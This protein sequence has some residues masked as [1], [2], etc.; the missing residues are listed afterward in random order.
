MRIHPLKLAAALLLSA[1]G[2]AGAQ[3]LLLKG[4]N[5]VDVDLGEIVAARTVLVSDGRI[6]AIAPDA[7]PPA[8]PGAMVIDARGRYLMPALWD[9]HVHPDHE[10]D[11]A[12]FVANGVGGVR[13]MAGTPQHLAWRAAI[14]L[15]EKAG[16]RLLV[17]GPIVEGLPPPE[18]ANVVATE[19]RRLIKTAEEGAV[20]VR[21]QK[22][23]GFDYIKVYNNIPLEAYRGLVAEA[24]RLR[25]PV[26][27]HVPFQAGL[28]GVLAARQ[29]SIEH[30]R[31]YVEK[32]VPPDAPV[33][34]GIDLRSRTLAWEYADSAWVAEVVRATRAAGVW[35]CPTLSTRIYHEPTS[36]IERYLATP[37]AEYLDAYSRVVL[38]HR[39]RTKWLS[40]F[41]EAD[42]ERA[43]RGNEKQ[44]ELLRAMQAAGVPLLAGTDTMGYGFALHGELERLVAA[45][46]T[47]RDVLPT[48]TINPARFAG[49][50]AEVGRVAVGY[51]ADLVLLDANPLADIRN[52]RKIN[53]VILR[54]RLLDRA[55]LDGMLAKVKAQHAARSKSSGKE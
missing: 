22:A 27:G 19:D 13:I 12:L 10:E 6:E 2:T 8:S 29:A 47:P 18:L 7:A 25:I 37:E 15:G 14:E 53:A 3:D 20:E 54:G 40:N 32:L 5:I 55:A 24:A 39:E 31:G 26:V 4:V 51:A 36:A 42:F 9:M 34:P 38:R 33:Q 52:T 41:S 50:E 21:R 35:Q 46:L 28:S 17:A 23:A 30:L 16:P 1:M 49:L 48:A 43:G 11:L 45:G 44:N